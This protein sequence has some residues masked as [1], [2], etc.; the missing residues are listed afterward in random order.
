M[1]IRLNTILFTLFF[2]MIFVISFAQPGPGSGNGGP[3]PCP[4]NN[5]NCDPGIPIVESI[6]FL[7]SAGMYLGIRFFRKTKKN[8]H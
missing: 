8:N 6:S 7:F 3:N 1:R 4:P 2:L 5:P